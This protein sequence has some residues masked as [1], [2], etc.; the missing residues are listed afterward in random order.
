MAPRT[1][2]CAGDSIPFDNLVAADCYDDEK[3]DS[4]K[5]DLDADV[6]RTAGGSKQ[7]HLS[8]RTILPKDGIVVKQEIVRSVTCRGD[9]WNGYRKL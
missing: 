8:S 9:S 3:S 5:F 2:I 1:V 4:L 6:E 7:K